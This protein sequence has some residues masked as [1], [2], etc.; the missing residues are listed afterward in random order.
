MKPSPESERKLRSSA[1]ILHT[2]LHALVSL[3]PKQPTVFRPFYAQIKEVGLDI[4]RSSY[5]VQS[6]LELNWHLL[7]CLRSFVVKDGDAT[8]KDTMRQTV[9][10]A[11]GM[12]DMVFKAVVEQWESVDTSLRSGDGS[13]SGIGEGRESSNLSVPQDVH[14]GAFRLIHHV[15]M[16]S[17]FLENPTASATTVPL[18][19]VLDLTSRLTSVLVPGDPRDI[20]LN[21][22]IG[23]EERDQLWDM[24]PRIHAAC[25]RL[26]IDIVDVLDKSVIPLA[27]NILEQACWVFR[28]EKYDAEVRLLTYRLVCQLV[29]II[30]PSMS[31]HTISGLCDI[32]RPCFSD[33]SPPTNRRTSYESTGRSKTDQ[34]LFNANGILGKSG[35]VNRAYMSPDPSLSHASSDLLTAVLNFAPTELLPSSIRIEIDRLMI[36]TSDKNGMLASVLNPMPTV[37][38]RGP[39]PSILPF[40]ARRYADEMDVEALIKPRMPVLLNAGGGFMDADQDGQQQQEEEEEDEEGNEG[41]REAQ[42]SPAPQ[43][44]SSTTHA[45]SYEPQ[46]IIAQA[47]TQE[48][49][50]PAQEP[51]SNKRSYAE[52]LISREGGSESRPPEESDSTATKK[53]RLDVN[54]AS[55]REDWNREIAPSAPSGSDLVACGSDEMVESSSHPIAAESDLEQE[56]Q[57]R[58]VQETNDEGPSGTHS[59]PVDSAPVSTSTTG[60][61]QEAV[62]SD[63]ELPVLNIE[64]D[65]E[66]D[67]DEMVT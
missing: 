59:A 42:V 62:S 37:R 45:T 12:A 4:T 50:E 67:D 2:V 41:E 5:V 65:T 55:V 53:V 47:R 32:L 30:G 7:L 51:P 21:L 66:E 3:V 28:A 24:L 58:Q 34:A 46:S 13:S 38:G 9:S 6:I 15:R 64:P 54:A 14:S 19:Y 17:A 11:H 60:Q 56:V 35:A 40:L 33:L 57:V 27:H 23:R 61:P 16:L 39:A 36:L 20:Q 1:P 18:G 31:K 26:F 22:Q 10:S 29:S 44:T 25:L 49:D 43:N 52:G 63:E 8:A 48:K